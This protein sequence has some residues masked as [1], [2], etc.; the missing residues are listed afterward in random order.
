M[1]DVI[2]LAGDDNGMDFLFP[3][4][5]FVRVSSRSKNAMGTSR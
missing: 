3:V 5:L 1:G 2:V 4:S